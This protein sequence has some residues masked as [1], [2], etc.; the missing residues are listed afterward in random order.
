[1]K[2]IKMKIIAFRATDEQKRFIDAIVEMSEFNTSSDLIRASLLE[3]SKRIIQ[4]EL[5]ILDD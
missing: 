2:K 4:K 1:M 5:T 3:Y